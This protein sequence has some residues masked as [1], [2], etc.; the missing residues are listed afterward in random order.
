MKIKEK[1][2]AYGRVIGCER[3]GRKRGLIRA[4]GFHMR[5]SKRYEHHPAGSVSE[6][7]LKN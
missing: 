2:R 6:K 5:F 7:K 3:C 1:K 4:Y